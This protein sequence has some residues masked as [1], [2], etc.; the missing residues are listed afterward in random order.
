MN[1]PLYTVEILR[2]AA[3]LPAPVTLGR[4]DGMADRRS[5]TCGSKV[6]TDVAL[7]REGRVAGLSQAVTACAFG[8]AS[9]S[10][11]AAS[12]VGRS[13]EEVA[14]AVE[15]LR[16]WLSGD[17]DDPGTWPG[18]S[19]LSAARSRIGRHGAIVLPFETLL[20]AIKAARR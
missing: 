12:A 18:L 8:Q 1:A 13:A 17:H 16:N 15:S 5:P 3:S 4:I 9:A 11:V 19:A 10:L 14:Q 20:D 6:H 2:L 7:D